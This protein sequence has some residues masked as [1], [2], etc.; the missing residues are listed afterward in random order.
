MPTSRDTRTRR[1]ARTREG[2]IDDT[3]T[4]R[5]WHT[6]MHAISCRQ[7]DS[8]QRCVTTR[9]HT[10]RTHMTCDNARITHEL[11]A[12][13]TRRWRVPHVRTAHRHYDDAHDSQ[14]SLTD[15]VFILNTKY[16]LNTTSKLL[17]S[18]YHLFTDA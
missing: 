4:T 14:E 17:K 12:R 7:R 16:V 1:V 2:N 13:T 9:R 5:E 10:R 6:N 3:Q 18:H 11:Y 15:I 8:A